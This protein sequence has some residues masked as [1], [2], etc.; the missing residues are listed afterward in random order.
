MTIV[1]TTFNT[2]GTMA[3][4]VYAV[5]EGVYSSPTLVSQAYTVGPLTVG[6]MSVINLNTA[7]YVQYEKPESRFI[8]H[9]EIYMD[10]QATQAAL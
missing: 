6:N 8:D 10:S 5:K 4:R 9:I 1:D 3:Y 7:Y 2:G